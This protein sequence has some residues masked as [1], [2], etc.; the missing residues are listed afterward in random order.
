MKSKSDHKFALLIPKERLKDLLTKGAPQKSQA[1][2]QNLSEKK[3]CDRG[4]RYFVA[5]KLKKNFDNKYKTNFEA[6][7]VFRTHQIV[8]KEKRGEY[9][10][11]LW[12]KKIKLMSF[13]M[14]LKLKDKNAP[15]RK[16]DPKLQDKF[17]KKN[18]LISK[19]NQNKSEIEEKVIF[20]N[21]TKKA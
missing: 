7:G 11:D 9:S 16:I 14:G 18:N 21:I 8:V 10:K 1:T 3:K 6:E 20:F 5:N 2:V 12:G 19:L 4:N 15:S 13:L 17:I